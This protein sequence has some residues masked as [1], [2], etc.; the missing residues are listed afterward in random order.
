MAEPLIKVKNLKKYFPVRTGFLRKP[1]YVHAVDDVSFEIQKGKIMSLV[2]ESGSGKT[3]VGRCILR[4][5]EPT[6]GQVIFNGVDITKLKYSEFKP[7]RPKLQAVFQDPYLSLNP[8]KTI[9]Q[10][11]ADPFKIHTDLSEEEIMDRVVQLLEDVGLTAEFVHRYPYELSGG[12]LQRVAIAR[13]IALDPEFIFLDEPTSSLD[14]SVQAQILNL[15]ID[16]QKKRNATYL[17]VTHNIHLARFMADYVGVMYVG[18]I[19]E[20]GPAKEVLGEP[21]HPYT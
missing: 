5:L 2:G 14:V 3:T 10:I 9:G 15:L 20:I 21:K 18:K 1:L 13:A 7:L 11:I 8:R 12:Q 17:F 4:I 19:L 16:L 6:A